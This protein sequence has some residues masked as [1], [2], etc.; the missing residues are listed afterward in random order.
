[1]KKFILTTLMFFSF[2]WLFSQNFV[3]IEDTEQ[4]GN[5]LSFQDT[6]VKISVGPYDECSG[7]HVYYTIDLD[8][9]GKEDVEFD[10][11]CYRGGRG[12][13]SF[14][15]VKALNN[16]Q[17]IV[18]TNFQAAAQYVSE[19]GEV[20]DTIYTYTVAKKYN[21]GD[22]VF[23]DQSSQEE[24]AIV[25]EFNYGADP[26]CIY[27][28]IK[29]FTEDTAFLAFYKYDEPNTWIYYIETYIRL[30]F[31]LHLMSA[32]ADDPTLSVEDPVVPKSYIYPNPVTDH[33]KVKGDFDRIEV[34]SL[35]G[36]LVFTKKISGGQT[37]DLTRLPKGLYF[38][39]LK[40]DDNEFIQKILIQ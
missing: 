11:V 6:L 15:Y 20:R 12:S 28:N 29:N 9:N 3:I 27:T 19:E 21:T 37:I 16:F 7:E 33:L 1:M 24:Y 40:S 4:G 2:Y 18:D 13:F 35:Q 38:V 34:Y 10:L 22:T 14:V 31:T 17:V 26:P 25:A 5:M 36:V 39:K 32:R 8:Q 23:L 30:Y